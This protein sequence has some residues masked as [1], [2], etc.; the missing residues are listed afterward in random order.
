MEISYP[1]FPDNCVVKNSNN[2]MSNQLVV[3]FWAEPGV[4]K[5]TVAASTFSYLKQFSKYTCELVS[6]FPKE[7]VWEN[8]YSTLNDQ[9][10]IFANQNHYQYRLRG[11][12][13]I[14]ITDSPLPLSIV[15]N[16]AGSGNS[17]LNQLV[18]EV[19]NSYNNINFLLRRDFSHYENV[20]RAHSSEQAA[21]IRAKIVDLLDRNKFP[22]ENISVSRDFDINQYV[23]PRILEKL[24]KVN[25]NG[26]QVL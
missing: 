4:G 19:F 13:D 17:T 10:Y 24:V 23:I 7:L 12:V 26:I 15:Y 1:E 3:N 21:E 18:L 11:K 6:E 8:C 2:F 14:I 25:N 5:S 9:I 20:G 16:P 22:Y